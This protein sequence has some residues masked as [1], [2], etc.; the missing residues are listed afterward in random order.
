MWTKS[1]TGILLAQLSL[2]GAGAIMVF[3]QHTEIGWGLIVI[4]IIAFILLAF[5]HYGLGFRSISPLLGM[6]LLGIVFIGFP[7]W[8][9]ILTFIEH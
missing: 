7:V 9:I 1:K 3:P 5:H 2:A 4:S 6:L 8:F